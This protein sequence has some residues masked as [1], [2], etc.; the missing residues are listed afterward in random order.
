MSEVLS[1]IS[2]CFCEFALALHLLC[3]C[4]ALTLHSTSALM[5]QSSISI[6]IILLFSLFSLFCY[7]HYSVILIILLFLL[8]FYNTEYSV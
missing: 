8:F 4:S 3:T 2:R 6:L 7:P 5:T 1:S